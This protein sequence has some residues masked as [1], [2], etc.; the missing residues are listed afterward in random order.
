MSRFDGFDNS[1]QTA[2]AARR[3]SCLNPSIRVF[4]R[5]N[6]AVSEAEK[7]ADAPSKKTSAVNVINNCSPAL[8]RFGN[9]A[10]ISS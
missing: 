4:G 2:R 3:R 5:E 8:H 1:C 6:R 9:T 10:L 7:N